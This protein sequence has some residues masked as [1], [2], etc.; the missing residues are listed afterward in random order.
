MTRSARIS[1]PQRS[2]D[3]ERHFTTLGLDGDPWD[4]WSEVTRT[5]FVAMRAVALPVSEQNGFAASAV[6]RV[7]GGLAVSAMRA[8]PHEAARTPDLVRRAAAE[9]FFLTLIIE[10]SGGLWQDHRNADLGPGDF[11]LVD[12]ARPYVFRFHGPFRSVVLQIPRGMLTSRCAGAEH[13]MAV[14]F[15]AAG[16][17]GGFVSPVLCALA[18]RGHDLDEATARSFTRNLLDLLA[19]ACDALGGHLA[20]EGGSAV[21]RRDLRR[22][23]TYLADRLHDPALTL[24]AAGHDLGFSLRYLH[25]L[26][27][28]AGTTP[29]TWLYEQRLDRARALLRT[30]GHEGPTVGSV[31]LSVGFKDPSH[32]SRAFKARYGSSPADYRKGRA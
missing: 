12:S 24:L 20:A 27:R 21:H 5:A 26:F 28:D 17:V 18:E 13:V 22:A 1:V 29:R 19:T 2:T 30:A 11:A 3:A 31:A 7:T 8:G 10:G 23:K 6:G 25:Q 16:N 14:P 32:F 9:D 4:Y 15:R